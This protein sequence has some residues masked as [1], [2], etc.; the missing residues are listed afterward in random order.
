MNQSVAFLRMRRSLVAALLAAVV[1]LSAAIG[2]GLTPADG[3]RLRAFADAVRRWQSNPD[4]R[5]V[6][7]EYVSLGVV[8]MRARFC[9]V[10]AERVVMGFRSLP[11]LPDYLAVNATSAAHYRAFAAGELPAYLHLASEQGMTGGIEM[12]EILAQRRPL[13]DAD[14][15]AFLEGFKLPVKIP[16]DAGAIASVRRL[17]ADAAPT[18]A[19]FAV[20]QQVVAR[21]RAIAGEIP[22]A[23][24][25]PLAALDARVKSRDEEL[26]RTKQ[27]SDFLAGVWAVGYGQIY[28]DGIEWLLRIE[29]AARVVFVAALIAGACAVI[30]LAKS[31]RFASASRPPPADSL[32]S[33]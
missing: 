13:S 15:V 7:D 29:L 19:P 28:L 23:T 14:I 30:R 27:V 33:R 3:A 21:L 22:P 2:F 32:A 4:F 9:G 20:R 26:W 25:D 1:V 17:I 5:A 16:T 12:I 8:A 24:P 18:A 10:P 6:E 31:R 11:G